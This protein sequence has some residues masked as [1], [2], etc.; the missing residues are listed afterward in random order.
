MAAH[1]H[2]KPGQH[3]LRHQ[4]S[5][6]VAAAATATFNVQPHTDMAQVGAAILQLRQPLLRQTFARVFGVHTS[7]GNNDWMRGKLLQAVG[8]GSRWRPE[9]AQGEGA[10]AA[11]S[12]NGSG[13]RRHSQRPR[14]LPAMLQHDSADSE[15]TRAQ[16]AAKNKAAAP[17]CSASAPKCARLSPEAPPSSIAYM[18]D[19]GAMHGAGAAPPMVVVVLSGDGQ[20]ALPPGSPT[21]IDTALPTPFARAN[22]APWPPS[23][24]ALSRQQSQHLPPLPQA[25][26]PGAAPPALPEVLYAPQPPAGLS[27]R[28]AAMAALQAMGFWPPQGQAH[29]L[30]QAQLPQQLAALALARQQHRAA[31]AAQAGWQAPPRSFSCL[32]TGSAVD[33]LA[34]QRSGS[35][36]MQR[37]RS[38][39][40]ELSFGMSSDAV[41]AAAAHVRAMQQA[42]PLQQPQPQL[43]QQQTAFGGF[44]GDDA[45]PAPVAAAP[46]RQAFT[47]D[48]CALQPAAA[49]V[50]HLRMSRAATAPS[51]LPTP[52]PEPAPLATPFADA[53]WAAC[54]S[55]PASAPGS[56]FGSMLAFADVDWAA[57]ASAVPTLPAEPAPV[58]TQQYGSGHDST[59]ITGCCAQC[60]WDI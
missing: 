39:Q 45:I 52:P 44:W 55:A 15:Q 16:A 51:T 31:Q 2:K 54:A 23:P 11:G 36:P 4:V 13:G 53:Q 20:V 14:R 22:S 10:T 12:S 41:A 3:L 8:L 9:S 7:S 21:A 57:C 18:A 6:D 48:S 19:S 43:A 58:A 59:F 5:Q 28:Q 24:G 32:P 34:L 42:S 26:L 38:L 49:A 40:P 46:A 56:P 27:H 25:A 50:H 29:V 60:T 47:F 33:S 1:A 35:V 17:L 37:S 30:P